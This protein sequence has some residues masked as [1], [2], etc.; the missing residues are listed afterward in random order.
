[1]FGPLRTQLSESVFQA[2]FFRINTYKK[3]R[4]ERQEINFFPA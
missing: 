4:G 3:Q 2:S 1:V